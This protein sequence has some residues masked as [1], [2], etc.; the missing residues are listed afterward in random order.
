VRSYVVLFAGAMMVLS[1]IPHAALGWPAMRGELQRLGAGADLVG[2]LGAGWMFGSFSMAALGLIVVMGALRFRKGDTSGRAS[3]LVAAACYL[4]F[5]LAA[6]FLRDFNPGFL[7]FV[8]NG[9]LAGAP[10]LGRR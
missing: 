9:I 1:S 10:A 4:S 6:F 7:L 8:V 2:G 5:G 3:I